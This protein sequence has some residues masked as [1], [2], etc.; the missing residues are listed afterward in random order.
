MPR[1]LTAGA[2]T[3]VQA[4]TGKFVHLILLNFYN[5]GTALDDP[6]RFTTNHSNQTVDAGDG[7]GSVTWN[8]LPGDLDLDPVVE[9]GDLSKQRA[10]FTFPDVNQQI[11]TKA[12][13]RFYIGRGVKIWRAFMTGSTVDEVV[14]PIFDGH[15][16]GGWDYDESRP[17]EGG[18]ATMKLTALSKVSLLSRARQVETNV[19]S[20]RLAFPEYAT[21]TFFDVVPK[22]AEKREPWGAK[23]LE[24]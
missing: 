11:I 19:D 17:F 1:D 23:S 8:A 10:T 21:D 5:D 20:Y 14:G 18:T 6:L 7:N 15:M 2:S 22:N 24:G 12:L 9:T 3:A 4:Q 16:S 13:S